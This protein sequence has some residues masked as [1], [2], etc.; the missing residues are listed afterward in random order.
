M[1]TSPEPVTPISPQPTERRPAPRP[2]PRPTARAAST[3]APKRSGFSRFVRAVGIL[4]LIAIL[5]AVIAAVVLLIT[6]AGQNTDLGQL[7][8]DNVNDQVQAIE[9][10]VREHT[11]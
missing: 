11:Q 6:D 4:I 1:Q 5:A 9:D 8:Q 3:A 10:F 7:I 2:A